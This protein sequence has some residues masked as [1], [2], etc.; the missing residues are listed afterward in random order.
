MST[1]NE[2]KFLVDEDQLRKVHRPLPSGLRTDQGYLCTDPAI[3]VRVQP[4]KAW[5][6]IKGPG[7]LERAEF[8]YEIP[9]EE[10]IAL[11]AMCKVKLSKIR[12]SFEY[13]PNKWD[14]WVVDEFL[15]T[16]EGLWLA[17]VELDHQMRRVEL[18]TWIRSE[19][20]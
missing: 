9:R 16:H 12:R 8:E 5:L 13:G 18:P 4:E 19:V 6:T 1:E 14:Q 20:T 17:E 11:L 10:G 3:R 7:L 15:G 2:R